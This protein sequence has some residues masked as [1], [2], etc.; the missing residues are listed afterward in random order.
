MLHAGGCPRVL[1]FSSFMTTQLG[2]GGVYTLVDTS[3]GCGS[4][5]SL[6]AWLFRITDWGDGDSSEVR[7]LPTPLYL[8]FRAEAGNLPKVRPFW[9][10]L[11]VSKCCAYSECHTRR[12][13]F[14]KIPHPLRGIRDDSRRRWR[15]QCA[16]MVACTT[17]IVILTS[18]ARKDLPEVRPY[19]LALSEIE[20]TSAAPLD[21][22][23]PYS[24]R[25]ELS[26]S[27]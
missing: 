25:E 27:D 10:A 18:F 11:S 16:R 3:D 15:R 8:S 26:R 1:L 9:F 20:S 14:M 5:R 6:V 13:H 2:D 23:V 12:P 24:L 21:G 4:E 22:P 17:Q 19:W 7:Y